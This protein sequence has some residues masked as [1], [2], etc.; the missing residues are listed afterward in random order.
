M[1]SETGQDLAVNDGSAP[2][3]DT[4]RMFER[5]RGLRERLGFAEL[6]IV[7]IV[8]MAFVIGGL[9]GGT[10]VVILRTCSGMGP[11]ECPP[12]EWVAVNPAAGLVAAAGAVLALIAL[13]RVMKL[14]LR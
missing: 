12:D 11:G 9:I 14:R 8:V 3:R 13:D 10:P 2:A 4:R 5:L 1:S 7:F 6:A